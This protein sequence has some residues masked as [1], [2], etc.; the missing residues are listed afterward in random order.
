M[1]APP[2][3]QILV[4]GVAASGKSTLA[5]ALASR[6][7]LAFLEGDDFHPAANVETMPIAPPGSP[8]S[9]RNFAPA[10]PRSGRLSSLVRR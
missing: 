5:R 3:L 10:A 9:W 2:P 4:M 6:L 7:G 8:P 1:T